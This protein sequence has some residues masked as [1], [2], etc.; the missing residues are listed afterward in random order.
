MT[1]FD[2]FKQGWNATWSGIG[3]GLQTGAEKS[4]QYLTYVP[5]RFF[6][7]LDKTVDNTKDVINNA[8]NT[9]SWPLVIGGA[10]FL[11]LFLR[12]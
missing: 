2:D 4:F 9:L 5:G 6:D 10:L 8:T 11:A 7:T 12:K 3:K 1:W